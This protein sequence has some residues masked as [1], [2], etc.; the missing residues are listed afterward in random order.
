[1]EH[2]ITDQLNVQANNSH[3]MPWIHIKHIEVFPLYKNQ[4]Q[5]L[6]IYVTDVLKTLIFLT[7]HI[8]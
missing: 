5:G 1:M 2:K 8:Q 3:E 4:L 7:T 6:S